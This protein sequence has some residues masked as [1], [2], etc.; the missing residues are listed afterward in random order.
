M[1]TL[2]IRVQVITIFT[3]Q[4]HTYYSKYLRIHIPI[5]TYHS[6]TIHLYILIATPFNNNYR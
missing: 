3:S 2:N 6:H 5:H 4:V 1:G